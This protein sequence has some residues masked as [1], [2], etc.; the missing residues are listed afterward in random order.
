MP[1]HDF[2]EDSVFLMKTSNL[3]HFG[4][5]SIELV[6]LIFEHTTVLVFLVAMFPKK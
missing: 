3:I 2:F 1:S 6:E 4:E 5:E